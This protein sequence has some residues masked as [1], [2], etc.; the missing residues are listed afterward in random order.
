MKDFILQFEKGT[1]NIVAWYPSLR[2]AKRQTKYHT[3]YL[4]K[5]CEGTQ[6]CRKYDWELTDKQYTCK[7]GKWWETGDWDDEENE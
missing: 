5:Y 2:E 4:K 6:K 1:K 3:N 7:W